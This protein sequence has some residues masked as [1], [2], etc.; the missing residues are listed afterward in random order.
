MQW[1]VVSILVLFML[2]F[3]TSQTVLASTK[4]QIDVMKLQCPL[5]IYN[6]VENL[7]LNET[8]LQVFGN[9][10][11]GDSVTE[12]TTG[13]FYECQWDSTIDS[14]TYSIILKEYGT[15]C[16][17]VIPCG[18]LG[19]LSDTLS[20][21]GEK[22]LAF[23]SL[24]SSF[25]ISALNP[26]EFEILDTGLADLPSWGQAFIVGIFV[27]CY[28]GIGVGIYKIVSPFGGGI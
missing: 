17:A 16:F 19:Y 23:L 5:P 24:I 13:T 1:F 10:T 12:N 14:P 8:G 25:F 15:M 6:G 9:I 3:I 21:A 27:F 26:F 28:V 22:F 18:H 2:G 11:Y 20:V 4:I 7:Y